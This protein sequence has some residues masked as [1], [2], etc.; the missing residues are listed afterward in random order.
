MPPSS[1]FVSRL[2]SRE[3]TRTVCGEDLFLRQRR[4]V[5][6]F[7]VYFAIVAEV[8]LVFNILRAIFVLDTFNASRTFK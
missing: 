1:S 5:I 4:N 6:A 8:T 3:T 2:F 7:H